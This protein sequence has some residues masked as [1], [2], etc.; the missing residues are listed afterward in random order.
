[1]FVD[2]SYTEGVDFP[3]TFGVGKITNNEG[4]RPVRDPS[5]VSTLVELFV[6]EVTNNEGR[7]PVRDPSGVSTLVELF[8]L[9]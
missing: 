8:E 5:G 7:S 3:H 6:E 4:R 2:Y 9:Y 1:L